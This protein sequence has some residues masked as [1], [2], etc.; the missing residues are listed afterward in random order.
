M[1]FLSQLKEQEA[2]ISG[3]EALA[4]GA[5]LAGV[6]FLAAVASL[7]GN[8]FIASLLEIGKFPGENL[9]WYSNGKSAIEA[10]TGAALA[11][12]KAAV[13]LRGSELGLAL[14]LLAA[15]SI[16]D[17]N[18]G[19][20]LFCVDDPGAWFSH[21]ESDSRALCAATGVPVLEPCRIESAFSLPGLAFQWSLQF[22]LPVVLRYTS[23]FSQS[24]AER[25]QIETVSMIPKTKSSLNQRHILL[26][27][28]VPEKK[29][30][31]QRRLL[32]LANDF[33]S[34]QQNRIIGEG[35]MGIIAVGDVARK[36]TDILD[37][38]S[39]KI[40]MLALET[41]FPFSENLMDSFRENLK[42]VLILEEGEPVVEREI[43]KIA[44]RKNRMPKLSGK[45]N[46]V[47]SRSGEI[48]HWQLEDI[49]SQ[50]NPDFE[51]D[52]FYF[53]FE[54]PKDQNVAKSFCQTLLFD[55][56]LEIFEEFLAAQKQEQKIIVVTNPD[57]IMRNVG[58]RNL[59]IDISITPASSIGIAAAIA[60]QKPHTT[61]F[62]FIGDGAF[63]HSGINSLIDALYHNTNLIV[64][65]FDNAVAASA[66][67]Q[68]T[69]GSG[70][71]AKNRK[72]TMVAIEDILSGFPLSYY[73]LLR[74]DFDDLADV[75]TE[76]FAGGGMR[77]IHLKISYKPLFK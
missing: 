50:W 54:E 56:A 59:K 60:G 61:V 71:N 36:T 18:G 35:E 41:V 28:D 57:C 24:S 25:V 26:P 11:G 42:S 8:A 23:G 33:S 66:G 51:S 14:D 75:L 20:I 7:P 65:I 32:K 38:T 9:A 12:K 48:Y 43:L 72:T 76:A 74:D 77:I 49:L 27:K 34:S 21:N 6:Q 39:N 58:K 55:P 3:E 69:P 73:K 70:I 13:S 67:Y 37:F 44:A 29:V 53:S 68:P 2:V 63:F 62:A 52:S 40:K 10:A 30:D 46:F 45:F 16:T 17:W 4:W 5:H 1:E 47:V 15:I 31:L 19:L 64:M 22:R